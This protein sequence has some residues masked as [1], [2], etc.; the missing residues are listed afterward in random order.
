MAGIRSLTS[1]L[2]R[3]ARIVQDNIARIS[4]VRSTGHVDSDGNPISVVR[5][6]GVCFVATS[7]SLVNLN[8]A[9]E[10]ELLSVKGFG[11]VAVAAIIKAREASSIPSVSGLKEAAPQ[12]PASSA[13]LA[14]CM[15]TCTTID[16]Y[17]EISL[18]EANAFHARATE[19]I[20]SLE[21]GI[22]KARHEALSTMER[23]RAMVNNTR[24][25]GSAQATYTGVGPDVFR[26][27]NLPRL[28]F[29]RH[30]RLLFR[31]D[32]DQRVFDARRKLDEVK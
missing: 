18:D 20:E 23:V 7:D 29:E 30:G 22:V 16:G 2:S 27:L 21:K 3:L 8:T 26:P 17:R 1:N 5:H 19:L 6:R 10:E 24:G 15:S 9:P 28:T 12:L 4:L 14:Q 31:Y 13:V 32:F 11:P 25:R